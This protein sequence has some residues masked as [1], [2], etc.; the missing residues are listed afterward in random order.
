MSN[1][2]MV[3][4]L[5]PRKYVKRFQMNARISAWRRK[6]ATSVTLGMS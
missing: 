1:V 4:I 3:I 5:T 2:P 6:D